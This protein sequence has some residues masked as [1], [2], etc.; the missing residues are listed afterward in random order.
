MAPTAS[1]PQRVDPH[2]DNAQAAVPAPRAWSD[3][4]P[5]PWLFPLLA[6]AASWVLILATWQVGDAIYGV[7]H[8]WTWHFMYKDAN[9]FMIVAQHGYP[10]H[11]V[12][13]IPSAATAFFPVFPML[14]R[15]AGQALG[16][17]LIGGLTV[18]VLAGAAS[19]VLVWLVAVRVRDRR[20][21][22]RAVLLYCLFP[23][24]M[25]FGMLYSE[26]VTIALAAGALLA[27]LS[28]R[29]LLAGIIGA[30]GT[31]EASILF[32]LAA[33]AGIVALQAI[34]QR[35]EWL[36]LAAP[37]LTP[38][39][40][41]GFFGYLGHRYHDYGFWFQVERARW[42][43]HIDWGVQTVH[44][45]LWN[46]AGSQLY[47]V[48]NAIDVIM[49]GVVLAGIVLMIV[50]RLPL[51][52]WLYSVLLVSTFLLSP[53]NPRPRYVL[54]AFPLFIGAGAKLPRAV[55]WPVLVL[56]AAGL[57]FLVAWWPNHYVGP[58]P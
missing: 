32:V 43:E 26:P 51:P 1:S 5:Y 14:I 23:G 20:T 13:G 9:W 49:T 17:Y 24:A 58:A 18:S 22:D 46:A 41:L 57:V 39:G 10:A 55:Y 28:R 50:A 34:W 52:L 37:A 56:S 27:L 33:V 53:A 19:A 2:P 25:A 42:D 15:L 35:R 36:A 21:A 44:L 11:L 6:F 48:V 30:V 38:L 45:L 8:P 29:W 47:K 31:A 4:L 3:R 40:A 54:C 16:S 7:S 12:K